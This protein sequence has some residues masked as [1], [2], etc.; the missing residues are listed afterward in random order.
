MRRVTR[1]TSVRWLGVSAALVAA[2]VSASSVAAASEQYPVP[3]VFT[4]NVVA[5]ATQ[6]GTPPP[7]A[8]N[9]TCRPSKAHPRPVV[10]VHGLFANMTDNWQTMPPLLA[11]NAHCVLPLTYGRD[12][13]AVSPFDQLAALPPM[14][15]RAGAP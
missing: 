7:G 15:Q 1:L 14:L 11:N 12:P 4:A 6:P 3:Y 5:G 10:L 2:L 9:W 13:T 8:N